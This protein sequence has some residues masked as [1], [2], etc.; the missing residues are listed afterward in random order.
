MSTGLETVVQVGSGV[1]TASW[2]PSHTLLPFAPAAVG[3]T[4]VAEQAAAAHTDVVEVLSTA[5]GLAGMWGAHMN[6]F[7]SL[8]WASSPEVEGE[9]RRQCTFQFYESC[10]GLS[11]VRNSAPE[12]TSLAAWNILQGT[13]LQGCPFPP[14]DTDIYILLLV[15][16][17]F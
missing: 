11:P 1:P 15:T 4:L 10:L 9:A 3:G 13:A 16:T 14:R 6:I 2:C 5:S 8:Q 17:K 7:L 12:I